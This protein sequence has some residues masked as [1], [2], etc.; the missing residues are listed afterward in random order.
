MH[1]DLH[2][3][4]PNQYSLSANTTM[5]FP[6]FPWVKHEAKI[7]LYLPINMHEPKE[8]R[9][10]SL[11]NQWTFQV[12]RSTKKKQIIPL[13]N[14]NQNLESLI[15]NNKLFQGWRRKQKVINTRNVKATGV[16]TSSC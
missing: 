16:T 4:D 5:P 10:L 3:C 13:P 12:G 15:N 9:L 6:S 11:E 14:L 2:D 7:T 1:A 8:G